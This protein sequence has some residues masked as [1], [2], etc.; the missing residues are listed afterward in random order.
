MEF[1]ECFPDS[2]YA[3]DEGTPSSQWQPGLDAPVQF[4][5]VVISEVSSRAVEG[6]C[7]GE[8]WIKLTN[9]TAVTKY[10]AG[11]VLHDDKGWDHADAYHFS[12]MATIAP[13]TVTI[14]CCNS[15]D[16]IDGPA[17]KIGG[18]TRS[19]CSRLGRMGGLIVLLQ[20]VR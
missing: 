1:D 14:V 12:A 9:P 3:M 15:A 7:G 16:G 8:D 4:N 6:V 11:L 5:Q 18:G 13:G 2:A 17:F 10:L 19:G 20:P